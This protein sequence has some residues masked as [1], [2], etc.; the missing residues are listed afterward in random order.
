MKPADSIKQSEDAG[1]HT[2]ISKA[3]VNVLSNRTM[4]RLRRDEVMFN[5]RDW[6]CDLTQIILYQGFCDLGRNL[7]GF[8]RNVSRQSSLQK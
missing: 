3:A 5:L 1:N 2:S 8:L 7:S 4:N 6:V